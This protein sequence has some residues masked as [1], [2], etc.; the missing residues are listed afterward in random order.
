MNAINVKD[1][2]IN[3]MNAVAIL[4]K[5]TRLGKRITGFILLSPIAIL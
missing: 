5:Y 3:I 2:I 4:Y 1:N